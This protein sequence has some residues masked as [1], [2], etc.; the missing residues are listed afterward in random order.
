MGLVGKMEIVETIAVFG[1]PASTPLKRD[2]N[3][4]KQLNALDDI[5]VTKVRSTRDT[6]KVDFDDG[7]IVSLP[8]KWFPR[9]DRATPGQRRNWR[10]IGRGVGVHWPDV[11]E[12]LSA[13]GL[14]AGRASIE[15][16]KQQRRPVKQ[17]IAA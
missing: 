5:R 6:L 14:L 12:D 11:D 15:F 7:R 9:L 13:A 16:I 10:L 8:L 1:S 3:E 17:K 2:V 4:M